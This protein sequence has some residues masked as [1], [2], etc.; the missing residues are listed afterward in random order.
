MSEQNINCFK[1]ISELQSFTLVSTKQHQNNSHP[2]DRHP[3]ACVLV[4]FSPSTLFSPDMNNTGFCLQVTGTRSC[5]A[6][7]FFVMHHRNIRV[8]HNSGLI[9]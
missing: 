4:Q 9:R 1:L 6:P 8:F 5:Y 7:V 3:T 2:D